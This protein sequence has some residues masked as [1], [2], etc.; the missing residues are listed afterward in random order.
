KLPALARH[1]SIRGHSMASALVL[2]IAA[3][4]AKAI[5]D[6][7]KSVEIRRRF[8]E[9]WKGSRAVLC[10]EKALLGEVTIRQVV[11]DCPALIWQ[12]FSSSIGCTRDEFDDY[13]AGTDRV[14]AVVVDDVVPYLSRIPLVHLETLTGQRL[15]APQSYCSTE[16]SERW[17]GAIAVAALLHGSIRSCGASD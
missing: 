14:C 15:V 13:T 11:S 9:S 7:R 10:A 1:S 3:Q 16:R 8:S 5:L 6:G 2:S 17:S 4:Y 12:R